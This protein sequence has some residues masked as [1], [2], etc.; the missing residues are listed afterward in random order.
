[1]AE[2]ERI[3]YRHVRDTHV[4]STHMLRHEDINGSNRLFGGRLMEW[5]D[6]LAGVAARLHCGGSITTA[7]VDKLEFH[8]PAYLND[9]VVLDAWV[10]HVER[11]SMEVR[12]DSFVMDP[13]TGERWMINQ[14]YLTEVCVDEDGKPTPIPW[15]LKADTPEEHAECEN[16]RKRAENRKMRRAHGF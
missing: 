15:G 7:A 6:D 2:V 12:V 3:G 14:A 4:T 11:T 13:G 5:I 8:R 9:I 16:A 10:T 1:M